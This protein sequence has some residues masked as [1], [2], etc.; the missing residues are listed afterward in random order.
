MLGASARSLVGGEIL[1]LLTSGMYGNPL[2]I[3]REYI[4]NSADAIEASSDPESGRVEVAL[5]PGERRV[6]IR[7]NGPG[8]SR[9]EA[10]RELIPIARSRKQRGIA[11][12]FRG[13][14]RLSALAFAETVSFRTRSTAQESVTQIEWNGSALKSAVVEKLPTDRIIQNC[15]RVS[16]LSGSDWP[17][18]FFEVEVGRVARHAASLILNHEAV[19]SYIGEVCPVPMARNFPFAQEVGQLFGCLDRPLSL[20]IVVSGSDNPATRPFGDSL[21]VTEN[22]RDTFTSFECFQIPSLDRESSAATGWIAHSSYL[23]AIPRNLGIRGLRAREGNIQIGGEG[24]FDHLFPEER[25]NRWCVGEVHI[26]DSRVL[27]NGRRDYFE[28]GPHVR[29]LENQLKAVASHIAKRCR[30]ASASRNR[31]RKL[32][33]TMHQL[34]SAYEL[35]S[36]GYLKATNARALVNKS[37]QQLEESRHMLLDLIS[38]SP[39]RR[40]KFNSLETRL[41]EFQPKRGRPAFGSVRSYEIATYQKIFQALT[42][43]SSS[44][45]IAKKTIEGVLDYA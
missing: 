21:P 19:R 9:R 1:N 6:S 24:I 39:E 25:F 14:G 37:L 33:A 35:A 26:L 10:E 15:V 3:Y 20:H 7:D 45:D 4:Q 34:E 27:P 17:D 8:L 43:L 18:S 2:A 29:N 11:R 5:A 13:I 40:A 16:E 28:P 32:L 30:K 41:K 36:S 38:S 44:P 31:I 12:G 22:F 42:E 23:G